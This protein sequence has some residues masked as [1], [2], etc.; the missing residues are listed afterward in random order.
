GFPNTR[1][2]IFDRYGKMFVDRILDGDFE[3]DGRYNREPLPSGTY[4]YILILEDGEK[5]S[6]HINLRN[7]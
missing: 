3:W 5:L 4:W 6:G 7:Y 1:L 2:Q